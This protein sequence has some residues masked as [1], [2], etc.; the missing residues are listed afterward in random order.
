MGPLAIHIVCKYDF[1]CA[2]SY[3]F[4]DHNTSET[5]ILSFLLVMFDQQG[6]LFEQCGSFFLFYFFLK[7]QTKELIFP[8]HCDGEAVG[9][10]CRT[11]IDS[12]SGQD[13]SQ[14]TGVPGRRVAGGEGGPKIAE[15]CAAQP[16][17][18]CSLF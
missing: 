1:I 6:T 9:D 12:R 14:L 10:A 7:Q 13:L 15:P 18:D 2:T 17:T 11:T 3:N 5:T 8:L 4:F 16:L